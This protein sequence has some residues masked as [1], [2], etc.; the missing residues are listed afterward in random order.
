MVDPAMPPS[1]HLAVR[2][3]RT[4]GDVTRFLS[5]LIADVL[6]DRITVGRSD[7]LTAWANRARQA[8]TEGKP[9]D[10]PAPHYA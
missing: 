4:A 2:G 3:L 6:A 7:Q 10:E 8:L 5:A 1:E 9:F